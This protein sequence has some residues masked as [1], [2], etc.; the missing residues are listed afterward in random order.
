MWLKRFS[1]CRRP[2]PRIRHLHFHFHFVASKTCQSRSLSNRAASQYCW[3]KTSRRL[4]QRNGPP[5]FAAAHNGCGQHWTR[6]SCDLWQPTPTAC[7]HQPRAASSQDPLFRPGGHQ[8]R[9]WAPDS[10]DRRLGDGPSGLQSPSERCW[11][12]PWVSEHLFCGHCLPPRLVRV[13]L[14]SIH[15][16]HLAFEFEHQIINLIWI[17]NIHC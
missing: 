17:G 13:A 7:P 8:S 6:V 9:R 5:A 2:C 14:R 3:N 12:L 4:S 1:M 15:L 11:S 16:G 10:W